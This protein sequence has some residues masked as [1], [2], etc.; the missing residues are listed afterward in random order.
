[1]LLQL[2]NGGSRIGSYGCS[3]DLTPRGIAAGFPKVQPPYPL[4][5]FYKNE[6]RSF[7]YPPLPVPGEWLAE[8]SVYSL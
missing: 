5:I 1:M 2:L 3:R 8:K 6:N 7:R 4:A